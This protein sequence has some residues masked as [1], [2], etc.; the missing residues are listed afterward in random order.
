MGRRR[1]PGQDSNALYLR[2][3]CESMQPVGD[4]GAVL[5][6]RQ[7]E[8]RQK[9]RGGAFPLRTLIESTPRGGSPREFPTCASLGVLWLIPF[10][11]EAEPGIYHFPNMP[12]EF[13]ILLD[14]EQASL[15]RE[16]RRP[17][18]FLSGAFWQGGICRGLIRVTHPSSWIVEGSMLGCMGQR[19]S[20]WGRSSR[21]SA[22]RSRDRLPDPPC[23]ASPQL[24]GAS[25]ARGVEGLR[26]LRGPRPTHQTVCDGA[27]RVRDAVRPR[28][29]FRMGSRRSILPFQGQVQPILFESAPQ[30]TTL[31]LCRDG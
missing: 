20:S 10:R 8:A 23:P 30:P 19:A 28:I 2:V 24:L 9:S 16:C 17:C 27:V 21:C 29:V 4:R 6:V 7:L 31:A 22:R 26:A 3:T 13:P 18:R 1:A 11:R 14:A 15:F 12:F 25:K 5:G